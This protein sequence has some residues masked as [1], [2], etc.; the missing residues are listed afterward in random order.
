MHWCPEPC[1]KMHATLIAKK[2]HIYIYIHTYAYAY[3]ST[4]IHMRIYDTIQT[5]WRTATET[6]NLFTNMHK[7]TYTHVYA[8]MR[9]PIN[10][11]MQ[12]YTY[13][14]VHTHTYIHIYIHTHTTC[15]YASP[16]ARLERRRCSNCVRSPT[17]RHESCAL[18][19]S[20]LLVPP[21]FTRSFSRETMGKR[22]NKHNQQQL[23]TLSRQRAT[24]QPLICTGAKPIHPASDPPKLRATKANPWNEVTFLP[25]SLGVY[26]QEKRRRNGTKEQR[27][28]E[29][30]GWVWGGRGEW[31]LWRVGPL[32]NNVRTAWIFSFFITCKRSKNANNATHFV[33]LGKKRRAWESS[34]RK[35]YINPQRLIKAIFII[36]LGLFNFLDSHVYLMLS[37]HILIFNLYIQVCQFNYLC[38]CIT[39]QGTN[40]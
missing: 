3:I 34:K 24:L 30:G 26:T 15:T 37:M 36:F 21:P 18:L 27:K 2:M 29:G 38:R 25:F 11:H 5:C 13:M 40:A 4:R 33:K 6:Q 28:K 32:T 31:V 35:C 17:W 1:S 23:N 7:H 14:H 12:I 10:I 9:I 19:L 22:R 20:K 39:I 16:Q 8:C